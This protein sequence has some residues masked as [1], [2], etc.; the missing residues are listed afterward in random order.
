[1]GIF[2]DIEIDLNISKLPTQVVKQ[3]RV[4]YGLRPIEGGIGILELCL[5]FHLHPNISD[6]NIIMVPHSDCIQIFQMNL[7]QAQINIF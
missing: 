3:Q 6:G 1:M 7:F 5:P 2:I 4:P